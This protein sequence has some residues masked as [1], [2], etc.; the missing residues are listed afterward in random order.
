M[1]SNQE[2][3][4]D[5]IL[6][7]LHSNISPNL[8]KTLVNGLGKEKDVVEC[9][10]SIRDKKLYDQI[11]S[12]RVITAN[13]LF[14]LPSIP[15]DY[16]ID[17]FLYK[18]QSVML[19]AKDK[20]GKSIISTQMAMCL[21]C[22]APFLNTFDVSGA[23]NVLY[24]QTEGSRE[25]TKRRMVSMKEHIKGFNT[26]RFFYH[27]GRGMQL[28]T[29]EGIVDL[30]RLIEDC[31]VPIDVVIIDPLYKAITGGDIS[32]SKD[33]TIF[34][35]NLD[36]IKEQYNLTIL[37]IQHKR[38]S[39][40]TPTGNIIDLGDEESMGSSIFKNYFDHTINMVYD[41]KND[42]RKLLCDTQRNGEI[43]K[44]LDLKLV[45][46]PLHFYIDGQESGGTM[47]DS[48]YKLIKFSHSPL[49]KSCLIQMLGNPS[50]HTVSHTLTKLKQ[51]DKIV[52]N[53]KVGATPFYKVKE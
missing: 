31:G 33:A 7:I 4:V 41:K 22:G 28:H 53:H 50:A 18:R 47:Y 8:K 46:E 10:Q 52:I 49:S 12:Q 45:E 32:S 40:K 11:C 36:A 17:N 14:M 29:M 9:L 20:V 27:Y 3:L 23:Y 6:D 43:N 30:Q 35:D 51:D 26:D 13:E 48:I 5:S 21:T 19:I 15:N 42:L 1:P 44:K 25:E 2:V 16:L 39:S 38:K 37:V 24:I 34:T